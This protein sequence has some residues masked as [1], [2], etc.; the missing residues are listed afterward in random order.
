MAVQEEHVVQNSVVDA[1]RVGRIGA[2][3]KRTCNKQVS[4]SRCNNDFGLWRGNE[5]NFEF[6]CLLDLIMNKYP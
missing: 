3:V 4:S 6:V 1:H 2:P 5:V